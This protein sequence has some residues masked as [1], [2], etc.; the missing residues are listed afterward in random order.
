[1]SRFRKAL[2][3][4]RFEAGAAALGPAA[5]VSQLPVNPLVW[6]HWN[7]KDG[8]K[9]IDLTRYVVGDAEV[10]FTG[11]PRLIEELA[12]ELRTTLF[13]KSHGT[14]ERQLS[15]I[16]KFFC[17]LT[18]LERDL[19]RNIQSCCD[20]TGPDG[21]GFKRFLLAEAGN[22]LKTKHKTLIFI[23]RLAIH[24]RKR[25]VGTGELENA[26]LLW[27]TIEYDEAPREH[28]D[29]DPKA[30]KA[31]Y[32]AAK[33]AFD[34]S[35]KQMHRGARAFAVGIDPRT[36]GQVGNRG[37]RDGMPGSARNMEWYKWRNLA[38][39]FRNRVRHRLLTGKDIDTT[40]HNQIRKIKQRAANP[41]W[42]VASSDRLYRL[43]APSL[44]DCMAAYGLVSLHTGWMDTVRAINVVDDD[45]EECNDW[46]S[47]RTGQLTHGQDKRGTV[48]IL[49]AEEEGSETD[50]D[51]NNEL[52]VEINATRPKTGRLHSALSLKTARYHPYAV[53]KAQIER[54]RY[55]RD[56]LRECRAALLA[57]PQ[58]TEVRAEIARVERKLRS[59]WLFLNVNNHGHK[60][61]GLLGMTYAVPTAF[62]VTL[63]Q[64]AVV[65]VERGGNQALVRAIEALKPGDIRDGYAAFL[66]AS[67]GGN[68][69]AVQQALY[70]RSI[71]T[72]RHYLRQK[73]QIAERFKQFRTMSQALFDEVDTGRTVDPTVLRL[74]TSPN[75]IT[76]ED[77]ETLTANRIAST[78][79]SRYGMGCMDPF[80]PPKDIAPNHV[81]DT[82]CASQR[83]LLCPLAKV[84]PDA[85][86]PLAIRHAE[87]LELRRMIPPGRFLTSS[88][89][90]EF[91]G[92]EI[93]R[94]QASG[95]LAT[96]FDSAVTSHRKMLQSG[97]ALIFD[98]VQLGA[99]ETEITADPANR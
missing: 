56:L 72:T 85:L 63:K 53:I 75:G 27:P 33:R 95:Y 62:K 30:L 35:L 47:D 84:T 65:W 18:E 79:R 89:C 44:S 92:I 26:R 52:S 13:G 59:P 4:E 67:S 82:L 49:A 3:D 43:S 12:P 99:L 68:I 94:E 78:F 88:L 66:F 14:V 15:C 81:V 39:L 45:F 28:Q 61:V 87:L 19:G 93:I 90:I 7:A 54:T 37:R 22:I 6:N 48:A 91:Q 8:F 2:D 21:E 55:L 40:V 74:A 17:Y 46:Y 20:L 83:C 77:R 69:F 98:A 51:L 57:K 73:R 25:A 36:T 58:T 50:G 29:V 97:E 5:T 24:V 31:V 76:D 70:H 38:V 34:D 32:I 11:R 64:Q 23:N 86:G 96:D 9:Q 41:G 1:M 71:A 60:A 42:P 16:K 10:G 80:N